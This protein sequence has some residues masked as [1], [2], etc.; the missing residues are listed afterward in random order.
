MIGPQVGG[1]AEELF[2]INGWLLCT[3]S[4]ATVGTPL[5]IASGSGRLSVSP[6]WSLLATTVVRSV[7]PT[8]PVENLE[9]TG[10]PGLTDLGCRD[11]N[12]WVRGALPMIRVDDAEPPRPT[13]TTA[14]RC[15]DAEARPALLVL[16]PSIGSALCCWLCGSADNSS[17]PEGECPRSAALAEANRCIELL[18]ETFL[19]VA[20]KKLKC[21]NEAR[22]DA[23]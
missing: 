16:S 19:G 21:W 13:G 12:A 3:N 9:R 2:P 6:C 14:S 4:G 18:R 7:V 23:N 17:V 8:I 11:A 15:T 5:G 1:S 10:S 22:S 20:P